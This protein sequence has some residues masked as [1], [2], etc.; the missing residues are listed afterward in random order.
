M[1]E[2][3]FRNRRTETHPGAV[4]DAT[5]RDIARRDALAEAYRA[6]QGK[7]T[8]QECRDAIAELGN[9]GAAVSDLPEISAATWGQ[10][11][12]DEFERLG[13]PKMST[14]FGMEGLPRSEAIQ[15]A[16]D[17]ADVTM[18]NEIHVMLRHV[19]ARLA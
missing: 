5:A 19:C 8:A 12:Q 14:G 2:S 11:V 10:R 17:V 4:V 15:K 18:L 16:R 3:D 1:N 9:K 13:G 6:I 7:Q